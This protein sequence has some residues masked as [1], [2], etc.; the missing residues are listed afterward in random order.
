MTLCAAYDFIPF[1]SNVTSS[2]QVNN[3]KIFL[4]NAVRPYRG[5][6]DLQTY[7]N[8]WVSHDEK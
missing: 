8:E 7:E 5:I 2:D 4:L 3:A 6:F 1:P